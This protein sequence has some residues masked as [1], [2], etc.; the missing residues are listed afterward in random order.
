MMV[1]EKRGFLSRFHLSG[2][3]KYRWLTL[4]GLAGIL[5]VGLSE[6]L[7]PGQ[8]TPA[9]EPTAVSAAALETAL[10][11]RITALLA[12]VQGVGDCRVMVTLE[13]GVQQV[14]ATDTSLTSAGSSEQT[15][16]VATDTG[17]VGLLL[18][19]V[20]PVVKGVAVVCAGGGDPAVC[21]QVTGLIATVFNISSRRVCVAL[22]N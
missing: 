9:D 11:E 5:L 6:W 1:Q 21:E 3:R 2:D 22:M 17:P 16:T 13:Q 18:T 7:S 8:T 20:Q 4:L 15:L 14:Y 10:E 12:R 19:E